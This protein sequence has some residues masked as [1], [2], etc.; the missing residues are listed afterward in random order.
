MYIG[1]AKPESIYFYVVLLLMAIAIIIAFISEYMKRTLSP[2]LYIHLLLFSLLLL[3]IVYYKFYKGDVP[4]Y[5]YSFLL[6]VGIAAFGYHLL[7][8]I[9]K[10]C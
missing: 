2:W 6:A 3:S 7:K 5:L 8:I 4:L 9:R 1:I 10:L